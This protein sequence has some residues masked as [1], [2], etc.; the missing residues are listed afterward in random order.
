MARPDVR[1]RLGSQVVQV[2][3]AGAALQRVVPV[4]AHKRAKG[5]A[6]DGFVCM[7][8]PKIFSLQGPS[9][10]LAAPGPLQVA[11]ATGGIYERRDPKFAFV[12]EAR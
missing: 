6:N 3:I 5:S 8:V 10:G 4:A 7:I 12:P 2:D 1:V 9:R 11:Y